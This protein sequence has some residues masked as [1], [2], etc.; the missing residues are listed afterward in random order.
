MRERER[1]RGKGRREGR[2]RQQEVMYDF[3]G[4]NF[5]IISGRLCYLC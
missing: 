4:N 2:G 1:E 5:D 3:E